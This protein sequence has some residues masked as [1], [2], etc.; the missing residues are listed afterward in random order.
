MAQFYVTRHLR[1]TALG[2]EEVYETVGSYKG[3][4]DAAGRK[5]GW[6]ARVYADGSRYAGEFAEGQWHGAG[7]FHRARSDG[8]TRLEYRGQHARGRR[9]G[10]GVLYAYSAGDPAAP[11]TVYEG[12]LRDSVP[13]GAGTERTADGCEYVGAFEGGLRS[14]RGAST[15]AGGDVF[16]GGWA[17]G[18]K[19]GPGLFA[20]VSA[21]RTSG[22]SVRRSLRP[23]GKSPSISC[24]RT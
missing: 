17:A 10:A 3:G 11:T 1:E 7:E 9:T 4:V 24:S 21:A 22:S 6:G 13:C 23:P 20:R 18:R 8:S 16:V 14:G 15:T 19:R 5:A 2:R 12:Q